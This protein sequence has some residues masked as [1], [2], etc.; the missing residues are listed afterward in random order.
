MEAIS[1]K[2]TEKIGE[3]YRSDDSKHFYF[4]RGK[5]VLH[6]SG[7]CINTLPHSVFKVIKPEFATFLIDRKEFNEHLN[8]VVFELDYFGSDYRNV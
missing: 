7:G 5:D 3:C 4:V 8:N 1:I 2:K 6:V